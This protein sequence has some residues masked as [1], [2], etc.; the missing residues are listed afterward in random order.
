LV[1]AVEIGSLS[2]EF[3]D[4]VRPVVVGEKKCCKECYDLHYGKA[5]ADEAVDHSGL[6]ETTTE[7]GW[8]VG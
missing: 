5:F 6:Y 8:R 3:E 7:R 2:T 1:A 4:T